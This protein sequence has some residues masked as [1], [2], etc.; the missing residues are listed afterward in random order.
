MSNLPSDV[1]ANPSTAKTAAPIPVNRLTLAHLL[2]WITM[3]AWVLSFFQPQR[4]VRLEAAAAPDAGPTQVEPIPLFSVPRWV[5]IA[6]MLALGPASGAG[7]AGVALCLWRIAARRF[8]FPTQPGHWLLLLIGGDWI[9]VQVLDVAT[10]LGPI[11]RQSGDL[12]LLGAEILGA[13]LM[14]AAVCHPQFPARWRIAFGLAACGSILGA[15][16]MVVYLIAGAVGKPPDSLESVALPIFTGLMFVA[17]LALL[18]SVGT[19]LVAGIV[20]CFHPEGFDLFHWAGILA[21]GIT[22]GVPCISCFIIGS[23]IG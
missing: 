22:V 16:M 10:R 5:E 20:D 7:A 1:T 18:G 17:L 9:L 14:T 21:F 2:L 3:T 6:S 12:H 4:A 8:G 11:G 15:A 23:G 13:A 19:A